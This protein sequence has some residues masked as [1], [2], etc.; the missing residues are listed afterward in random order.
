MKNILRKFLVFVFILCGCLSVFAKPNPPAPPMAKTADD[1]GP[2][3]PPG[4]DLP[5]DDN[6]VFLLILGLLLGVYVTCKY[7]Y[8]IKAPIV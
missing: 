6:I 2:V 4:L 8:K 5:V 7:H 3:V 1:P